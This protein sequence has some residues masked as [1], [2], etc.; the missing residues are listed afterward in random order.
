VI[1]FVFIRG[2]AKGMCRQD[3][4]DSEEKLARLPGARRTDA[5]GVVPG[6]SPEVYVFDR[7]TIQW[8]LYRIPI[9]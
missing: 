9:S 8:N 6:P 2:L 3:E 4:F 1:S 7:S 5:P